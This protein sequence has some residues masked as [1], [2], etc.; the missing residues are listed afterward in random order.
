MNIGDLITRAATTHGDHPAFVTDESVRSYAESLRRVDALGRGL[1]ARGVGCGDRVAL[2]ARNCPEYL[3]AMFAVWKIGAVIVPL[4]AAFTSAELAWHLRDSAAAALVTDAGSARAVGDARDGCAELRRVIWLDPDRLDQAVPRAEDTSVPELVRSHRSALELR[5]VDRSPD[6]LAWLGY[7]SGTTGQPKGAMLSHR[8]LQFQAISALADVERL[9]QGDVG[10]HAAP[11]SH[12]SGYNALVFTMKACT[13]V[14]HRPAGFDPVLFLDQVERHRVAAVFLVPTQ[15]KLLLEVPGLDLR[16]LSSLRWIMYGGAP[17]Y[18]RDQVRA[19][20]TFGPVLVQIFGQTESPMSGTVLPAD[21]H[22]TL[23]ADGRE[24]SVGRAR[25]GIE[26]R[27]VDEH[28][29]ELPAGQAG[30]ICLRGDTLMTGYWRRPDATAE[31]IV[32]GWLHTGDIGRLDEHGYLHLL[33]RAKDLIIS[34][35]LNVYPIEVE[36]VLLRHPDVVEA[37]VIG[38]PD[39]KW[40]EAVRA[41]VVSATG[42]VGERDLIEFVGDHLAGFKKPKAIDFVDSLPRTSYGKIAKRAVRE[43]YWSGLD[44]TI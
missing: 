21:E 11:L 34:G 39:D 22:T 36:D 5:S 13:Q 43:K 27:V 12:G 16:D 23:V 3:E 24:V 1:I 9:E 29:T 37:C 30:E 38:V 31:T 26:L 40:G 19:L 8:A 33:D 15:I 28:G 14:F 7:T 4:N 41:V 10:M 42:R 2:Y 6:D 32:D 17:M 35:G 44:R 20:Q 18:R 25:H